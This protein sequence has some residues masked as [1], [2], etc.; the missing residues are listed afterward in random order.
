MAHAL[1]GS[2]TPLGGGGVGKNANGGVSIFAPIGAWDAKVKFNDGAVPTM[3][4]KGSHPV[5]M[6]R[7]GGSDGWLDGGCPCRTGRRTETCQGPLDKIRARK[8]EEIAMAAPMGTNQSI[9][10]EVDRM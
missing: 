9:L 10:T 4:D 5:S 3:C 8:I 1:L 2:S 6:G 7:M